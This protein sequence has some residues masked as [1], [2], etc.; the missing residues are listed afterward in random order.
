MS[1]VP[2]SATLIPPEYPIIGAKFAAKRYSSA[3]FSASLELVR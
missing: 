3:M 2:A 1:A